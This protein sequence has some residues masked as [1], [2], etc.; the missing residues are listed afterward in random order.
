M[1]EFSG[2]VALVTGAAVG[3]GLATAQAFAREGCHV[4]MVDIDRVA[5]E[6]A[7]QRIVATGGGATFQE[8]DVSD[9]QAVDALFDR[10]RHDL[11]RLDYGVNNAGVDLES[12]PEPS[13]DVDVFD[14]TLATNLRGVFLC[15]RGEIALM[16][17]AG[18]GAIVNVSSIGGL[19][20][21]EGK[22]SYIASK[23]GV[24]G[25][26]RSAARQLA[27]HGI[28]VNALCPGAV[29]TEMLQQALERIPDGFEM[30]KKIIPAHRFAESEEAAQAILWLCSEGAAYVIGHGLQ[31]D[32]G[33][34]A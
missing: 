18:A 32:G 28:R 25:L 17:Q 8:C 31:I 7:A 13:W 4:V 33:M 27:K 34:G 22:P 29:R 19:R 10:I 2:K 21:E 30:V 11:G 26:T 15:M 20:G 9:A 16:R 23:H 6:A 3:I 12:A 14:R 1:G 5:G 24:M